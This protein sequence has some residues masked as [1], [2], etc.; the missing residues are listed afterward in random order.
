[1]FPMALQLSPLCLDDGA[2]PSKISSRRVAQ[3]SD[4]SLC[5]LLTSLFRL[6]LQWEIRVQVHPAQP[7]GQRLELLHVPS[8]VLRAFTATDCVPSLMLL[9]SASQH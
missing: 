9:R 6:R 7:G 3:P 2:V 1:M 5:Q 4:N 8:K